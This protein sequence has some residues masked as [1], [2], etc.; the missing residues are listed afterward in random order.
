[1]KINKKAKIKKCPLICK[2]LSPKPFE[3]IT[4]PGKEETRYINIIVKIAGS[5]ILKKLSIES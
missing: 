1:M 5:Q 4:T 2:V 3:F